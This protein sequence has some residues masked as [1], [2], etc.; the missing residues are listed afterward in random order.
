VKTAIKVFAI[1][2]LAFV[3]IGL[4]VQ[5]WYVVVPLF[6]AVVVWGIVDAKE[7][8]KKEKERARKETERWLADIEKAKVIQQKEAKVAASIKPNLNKIDE[9]I[10]LKA[11]LQTQRNVLVEYDYFVSVRE[12][13]IDM[14]EKVQSGSIIK[15]GEMQKPGVDN[16][17]PNPP[18]T[19]TPLPVI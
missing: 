5:I 6:V 9:L 3:V 16:Y 11:E 18:S 1:V 19:V 14:L 2:L 12:A 8:R 15:L 10:G 13:N 17:D 7:D 4:I